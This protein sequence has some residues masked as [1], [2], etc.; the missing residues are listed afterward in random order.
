MVERRGWQREGDGRDAEVHSEEEEDSAAE[1]YSSKRKRN[2]FM[3]CCLLR[4]LLRAPSLWRFGCF[5]EP[6][7]RIK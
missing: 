2:V 7:S 6:F 4:I 3:Q 1:E 5:S